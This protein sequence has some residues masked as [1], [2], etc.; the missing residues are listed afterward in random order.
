MF[1]AF[2][3]Y[4]W[5][6]ARMCDAKLAEAERTNAR[7]DFLDARDCCLDQHFSRKLRFH[8]NTMGALGS[9]VVEELLH[10]VFSRVLLST[11]H[12]ENV[13]AHMRS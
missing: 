6:C 11:S 8:Y 12:A 9:D 3:C 10:T 2:Q 1:H 5:L 7:Q 13:F 4:P